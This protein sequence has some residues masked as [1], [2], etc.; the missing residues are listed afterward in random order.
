MVDKSLVDSNR[1]NARRNPSGRLIKEDFDITGTADQEE[2]A[3]ELDRSQQL[4]QQ[5]AE[6]RA[7][8][9]GTRAQG[10][11][12]ARVNA[13]EENNYLLGQ[14]ALVGRYRDLTAK[15]ADKKSVDVC[16]E[17][18]VGY[19][20]AQVAQRVTKSGARIDTEITSEGITFAASEFS[21]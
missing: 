1:D 6:Q 18:E 3:R 21:E 5:L 14:R 16:V 19:R 7:R 10:T 13:S 4:N 2:L 9:K 20:E 8:I 12:N 17:P 11:P 15:L